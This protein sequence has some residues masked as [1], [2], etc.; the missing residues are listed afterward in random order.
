MNYNFE[1]MFNCRNRS[2]IFYTVLVLLFEPVLHRTSLYAL[3]PQKKIA[4]YGRDIWNATNG[5]HQYEIG[6]ITQTRDGYLWLG[7]D[8][9][10]VR[11]D[12]VQF[13]TF[14][15]YN[16]SAIKENSV[17]SLA[18]DNEGNLWIGTRGGG[19]LRYRNG[20][21]TNFTTSDGL[22]SNY[23]TSLLVDKNNTLIIGERNCDL[24]KYSGNTFELI[25]S[26]SNSVSAIMSLLEDTNGTLWIGE[27]QLQRK[28]S[29]TDSVEIISLPKNQ[30]RSLCR[31]NSGILWIGKA[32][33][34]QRYDGTSVSEFTEISGLT[35]IPILAMCLDRDENFWIA[36]EGN[37]LFRCTNGIYTQFTTKEGI[38]DN[39]ILSLFE[40]REGSF[41][42]GTR[43]SGLMR[44]RN[45]SISSISLADGLTNE[46]TTSIFVDSQKRMWIGTRGG[47]VCVFQDEKFLRSYDTTDGLSH[48]FVR[49]IAED[50]QGNMWFGTPSKLNVLKKKNGNFFS[51]VI[52]YGEKRDVIRSIIEN[53]DNQLLIAKYGGG[54]FIFSE[55]KYM[56]TNFQNIG[57][58]NGF[59]RVIF[60]D[61]QGNIWAGSQYGINHFQDSVWKN[62]SVN[63]GLSHNEV[64]S[65]ADDE[66][67]NLWIGTYGG[68]INRFRNG[69]F[70]MVTKKEGLFDDVVFSI[71]DDMSGNFWMSC[72]K[73]IFFA[74]K[75][76]LNDVC[77]GKRASVISTMFGTVDGMPS[78]ECNGGSNPSAWR[79]SDGKLYFPTVKGVVVIDPR[80]IHTNKLVPN[81]IVEKILFEDN[82]FISTAERIFLPGKRTFEI[83]YTALSFVVPERVQFQCILEGFDKSWNDVGTRRKAYYTNLSP[84]DY[85]FKVKACNNDGV[86]NEHGATYSFT[87]PYFFWETWWFITVSVFAVIW[88]FGFIAKLREQKFQ[89]EEKRKIEIQ[90]ELIELE[91]RALR[92]QMNPHFIFNSL[93]AIQECILSENIEAAC[94]YLSKFAQ[95]IRS[96]LENSEKVAVDLECELQ[97]LRLYLELESLRF[98]NGFEFSIETEPMEERDAIQIPPMLIQPYVENAIWHGLAHK[99]GDKKLQIRLQRNEKMFHCIIEDNG[100]GR[101]RAAE[102]TSA[103]KQNYESKG[104]RITRER[105]AAMNKIRDSNA[106]V[107]I[108]DLYDEANKPCGTRVELS[109]QIEF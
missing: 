79:T 20:H 39:R 97:G 43:G 37:G 56:A 95:L 107:N 101:Q 108:V 102:F 90:K 18:E 53:A 19:I 11:F 16:T 59:T 100:I 35:N 86:W 104:M 63:D 74:P 75:Q 89:K 34:L 88:V 76:Q 73:G 25:A 50:S 52:S 80:N 67:G 78:V 87:V 22:T 8:E 3:D 44:L 46:Y 98:E 54:V 5:L 1:T 26:L 93:N 81:V 69:K 103:Y 12:G 55:E 77:D 29:F 99:D 71:L 30:T 36:T 105:L 47:G 14:D 94:E 68:G 84:G 57:M 32:S 109:I 85:T 17:S 13:V 91:S 42:I 6:V 65:L 28:L 45:R 62:Y 64:F 21:F 92:A 72:N 38:S 96:I 41:W 27:S 7:T 24:M 9:G 61:R 10:V 66:N 83:Q 23:I 82:S 70:Q 33:G 31:D 106:R 51:T 2:F 40:D 58:V 60:K 4:Q 48:N 49:A 15:K